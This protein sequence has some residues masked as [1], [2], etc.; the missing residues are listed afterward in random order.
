MIEKILEEMLKPRVKKICTSPVQDLGYLSTVYSYDMKHFETALI[1]KDDIYVLNRTDW[2]ILALLKHK[3]LTK[4]LRNGERSFLVLAGMSDKID[5]PTVLTI[6]KS[7]PTTKE[8]V[9]NLDDYK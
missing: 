7:K 8:K 9:L 6:N 1:T 3:K 2:K 5:Y 4:H